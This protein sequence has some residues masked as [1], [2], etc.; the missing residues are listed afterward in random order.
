MTGQER[1]KPPL[2]GRDRSKYI[3]PLQPPQVL[4]LFKNET[5]KWGK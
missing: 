1:N 4:L 2:L 5:E 3:S